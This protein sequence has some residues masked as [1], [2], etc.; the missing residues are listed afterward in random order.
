MP[1]VAGL[2]PWREVAVIMAMDACT[3]TAMKEPFELVHL[4]R[5]RL[6][7]RPDPTPEGLFLAR[8]LISWISDD[9]EVVQHRLRPELPSFAIDGD[10]ARAA[11]DAAVRW[12]DERDTGSMGLAATSSG[13]S[14]SR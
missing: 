11:R 5:Y 3:Q 14:A 7:C 13:F 8:V 1:F 2:W 4:N 6:S 12:L 10:A 9:G